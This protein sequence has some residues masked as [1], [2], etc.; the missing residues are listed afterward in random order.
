MIETPD[1]SKPI[2]VS[3]NYSQLGTNAYL[4]DLSFNYTGLEFERFA[5]MVKSGTCG[6]DTMVATATLG[7]NPVPLPPSALLLGTGLVGLVGLGWR[8]SRQSS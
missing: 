5:F 3:G 8:R 1:L 2:L 7:D 4:V 6:N